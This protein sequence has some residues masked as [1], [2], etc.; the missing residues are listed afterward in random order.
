MIPKVICSDGAGLS[1]PPQEFN[2]I[3]AGKTAVAPVV[4][5]KRRRLIGEFEEEVFIEA[6]Q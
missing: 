3:K 1:A 6:K 2:G 4:A 5:R